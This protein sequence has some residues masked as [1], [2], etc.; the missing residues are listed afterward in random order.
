MFSISFVITAL[1]VDHASSVTSR[2]HGPTIHFKLA[3]QS[4]F[5]IFLTFFSLYIR[6]YPA[7]HFTRYRPTSSSRF[8]LNHFK[9]ATHMNSRMEFNQLDPSPLTTRNAHFTST[10]RRYWEEQKAQQDT[11]R[12]DRS[13]SQTLGAAITSTP[14]D[15][16]ASFRSSRSL[17]L[18]SLSTSTLKSGRLTEQPFDVH[19]ELRK[20][21]IKQLLAPARSLVNLKRRMPSHEVVLRTEAD[22][23]KRAL[24]RAVESGNAEVAADLAVEWRVKMAQLNELSRLSGLGSAAGSLTAPPRDC[25]RAVS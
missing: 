24:E 16:A 7:V 4:I 25:A 13:F 18:A 5:V 1:A 22:K 9:R 20:K 19:A 17:T 6:Q 10:G 14:R 3:A 11:F 8:P 23:V 2:I 15:P 21:S 12:S